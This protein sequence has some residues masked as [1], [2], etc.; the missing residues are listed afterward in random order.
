M[1]ILW[2]SVTGDAVTA[3]SYFSTRE[4]IASHSL[5]SPGLL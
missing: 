3:E 1:C 5:Q 4:N 2:I